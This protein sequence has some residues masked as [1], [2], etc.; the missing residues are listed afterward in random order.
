MA[1]LHWQR[2]LGP[3]RALV[4]LR[5]PMREREAAATRLGL[6][7]EPLRWTDGD[8]ESLWLGP[9]QWLLV[10]RSTGA[11]DMI[12]HCAR[13]LGPVLHVASDATDALSVFRLAGAAAGT[14]L[15]MGS[16]VDFGPDA[17]G[18]RGCTRTRW[19]RVPVVVRRRSADEYELFVESGLSTYVEQWLD[20]CV[21]EAVSVSRCRG[22]EV[23][24]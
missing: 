18:E 24:R 22:R 3:A 2:T 9:D 8:P 12:E 16:G 23:I 15:A 11:P 19:M 6:S 4:H 13:G 17:F 21:A 14:L 5:V 7:L 20:H 1:D 10:G